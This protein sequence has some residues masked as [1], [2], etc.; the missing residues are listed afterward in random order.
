MTKMHYAKK[1]RTESKK[2]V[3][4]CKYCSSK[5]KKRETLWYCE[6]CEIHFTESLQN[7]FQT[8]VITIAE[9]FKF[10]Q[11]SQVDGEL[12]VDY[13]DKLRHLAS[14]CDF[15]RFLDQALRDRLVCGLRNTMT[16]KRL[17]AEADLTLHHAVEIAQG[18]EIAEHN[19]QQIQSAVNGASISASTKV[20]APVQAVR[21]F[22]VRSN[23]HRCN[24]KHAPSK[25]PFIEAECFK[26]KKQGHMASACRSRS[27]FFSSLKKT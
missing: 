15:E 4:R 22:S 19:K 10:H 8:K 1:K 9:R 5:G 26:C 3:S 27:K 23:C 21:R 14:T 6:T 11:H 24:G 16:Q 7:H 2:G 18:M 13:T 20:Q 25:C 12:I 17:L